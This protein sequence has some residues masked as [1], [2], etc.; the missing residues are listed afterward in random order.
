MR[1][2]E[3]NLCNII[4]YKEW[5][6][7]EKSLTTEFKHD[8]LSYYDFVEVDNVEMMKLVFDNQA[9]VVFRG[10]D[11]VTDWLYNFNIH[12]HDGFHEGF[13]KLY[14]KIWNIVYE[15]KNKYENIIYTGHSLGGALATVCAS[16]LGCSK[17]VTFGSPRVL[18]RKRKKEFNI[19]TYRYVNNMDIVPKFPLPIRFVHTDGLQY[20]TKSG[21][22]LKRN[23]MSTFFSH[24][25]IDDHF[26]KQ[27]LKF[28]KKE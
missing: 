13:Y 28:I 19:E 8:A 21:K 25:N 6:Q 22:I 5:D 15:F 20:I 14:D 11:E 16:K 7:V 27:Y 18:T 26:M 12:E 4:Y 10:T 17:L 9:Y 24:S 2:L 23:P 3:A 1:V